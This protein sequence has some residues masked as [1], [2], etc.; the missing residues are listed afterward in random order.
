[1]ASQ[2]AVE[3]AGSFVKSSYD[4]VLFYGLLRASSR[5]CVVPS[6][7]DSEWK[8]RMSAVAMQSGSHSRD[9]KHS[10]RHPPGGIARNE[11]VI[12]AEK[13]GEARG[14]TGK[15][16]NLRWTRKRS[17]TKPSTVKN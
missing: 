6:A 2:I 14:R 10:V 3:V 1:M 12:L 13:P 8:T 7:F 16:R 17:T 15:R 11:D 9:G 4:V 5:T